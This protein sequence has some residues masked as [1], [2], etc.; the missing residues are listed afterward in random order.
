M[1]FSAINR[2]KRFYVF[3]AAFSVFAVCIPLF[4]ISC[5]REPTLSVKSIN[6]HH[7]LEDKGMLYT[8]KGTGFSHSTRIYLNVRA[9]CGS[10]LEKLPDYSPK[11]VA[12]DGT[13]LSV[14]IR[15]YG[16]LP[17]EHACLTLIDGDRVS[18]PYEIPVQSNYKEI[19]DLVDSLSL[20]ELIGQT[21]M[22][23]F[24]ALENDIQISNRGL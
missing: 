9:F 17:R 20:E 12:E 15:L 16:N 24:D 11:E 7:L 22:V 4:F 8:L 10:S 5:V 6:P 21:L 23:G 2:V 3:N 1:S 18:T 14:Y 13:W 19:C